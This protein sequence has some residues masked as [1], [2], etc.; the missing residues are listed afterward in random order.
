MDDRAEA[1]AVYRAELD[2]LR[3]A[4]Q[5]FARR[6]PK[7][8]ERLELS[9]DGSSDPHVER[10]IESF[11][12]LTSRLQRRLDSEFPEFTTAL[13]GLL[14]PNLVDPIPPMT[15]ARIVADPARGKLTAGYTV[16]RHTQLFAHTSN[17]SGAPSEAKGVACRFRTAYPTTLWPLEVVEADF[18]PKARFD[19][20]AAD[21]LTASV[22]RLRLESRGATFS[23]L[24]LSQLRFHLNGP[25]HVTAGLY[26]LLFRHCHSIALFCR[27]TNRVAILPKSSMRAVGFGAEDDVIPYPRQSL[28]AYRILQEYFWLP[29]KFLFFDLLGLDRNPSIL[30]LDILFLLDTAPRDRLPLTLDTFALGCTPIVNLFPRTS[31]PIR[32]DHTQTS[33]RILA[34]ARREPTTEIH[35]VLAVS[36]TSNPG[37]ETRHL[38]PV[39]STAGSTSPGDAFWYARRTLTERVG[40]SGTDVFLSFVDLAFNP[41]L[42][43]TEVAFAHLLCTNRDL[44]QQLPENAHLQTEEPGPIAYIHCLRKP[45]PAGYPPLGG[46][47]RWALLSN[48]SLNTLSLSD[49]PASLEAFKKI[50]SLYDLGRSAATQKEVAGIERMKVRMVTRRRGAHAWK[51]FQRGYEVELKLTPGTTAVGG[52]VLFGQVLQQVLGLHAGLNSFVTT[53]VMDSTQR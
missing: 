52:N 28:P 46:A 15:V 47:S 12:L 32:L 48:L 10:L 53:R 41:A 35:S 33:Y 6:H 39:Y 30:D 3:N 13:L 4:G 29:E 26:S 25:S 24:E 22:L 42:P 5:S 8:A 36:S 34:D 20:L 19:F 7:V 23:D 40:L 44:A 51:S 21:N 14:Y 17:T 31:E 18:V 11:A 43:P 50:L 16:P 38:R 1:L 2:Y 37:D 9:R 49:D 45:T 27:I